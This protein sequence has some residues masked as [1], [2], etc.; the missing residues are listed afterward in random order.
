MDDL[1]ILVVDDETANLQKL[2]RTFVNRFP[3]LAAGSGAEAMELIRA[4]EGIAVIIADQR[5]PDMTGVELLR[6]SMR[7]LPDAIRI[8]LTGYTDIDV[9]IEAINS[10][11]VYRYIVKPWDPPDLLM[12]VQR[13]V[14]AYLMAKENAKFRKELI[15]R[16]R[17]ARELEIASEIQ[18]YIL[19][20]RI[21]ARSTVTKLRWSIT[22]RAKSEAICTILLKTAKAEPCRFVDRRCFRQIDC[23]GPLWRGFQRP[24]R[25]AVSRTLSPGEILGR[26]NASLLTRYPAN[27]YVAVA[28]ARLESD[29]GRCVLANGGMPFPYLV[30]GGR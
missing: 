5:M 22:R 24:A 11:K 21:A 8:I 29:S 23:G 20:A 19:P 15:R 18:R 2:R 6:Q 17:L 12:T 16:E 1:K 26:A 3:V 7:L 25:N 28:C 9:L 4:H 10:C 13:G 30:R 14:E 27:N